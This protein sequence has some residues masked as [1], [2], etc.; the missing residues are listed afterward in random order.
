M[1]RHQANCKQLQKKSL[2]GG[3][4]A[5]ALKRSDDDADDDGTSTHDIG[6]HTY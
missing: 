4:R 1:M 5:A 3:A 6:L 2:S